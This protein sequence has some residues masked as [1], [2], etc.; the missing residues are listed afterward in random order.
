MPMQAM[1]TIPLWMRFNDSYKNQKRS[2]N[3]NHS[4]SGL[5]YSIFVTFLFLFSL[6]FTLFGGD[7]REL[8]V[9]GWRLNTNTTILF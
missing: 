3:D 5:L 9:W 8:G 1:E 6:H 2:S 4:G 7:I